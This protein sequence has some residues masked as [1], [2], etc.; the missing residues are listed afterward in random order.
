MTATLRAVAQTQFKS[1]FLTGLSPADRKTVSAAAR[2]SRFPAGSVISSQ[3]TVAD[4]LF[5]LVS[6]R[7]RFFILT[8]EG[9]KIL[10]LWLPVGEVLG[11]AALEPYPANY[12][13]S[14]E[15]VRDSTM[16]VWDRPTIRQLAARFPRLLEN[17]LHSASEYL[18]FY[19]ATHIALTS[20][21]A[22]QRLA[23]LLLNL[24]RGL[25]RVVPN[26]VELDISN[27]ELAQAA[28][29]T[30]FTASRLI[31]HWQKQGVLVKT[32]RKILLCS[33][34]KLHFSLGK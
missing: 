21:T 30:H 15:A 29:V 2:H 4:Q 19:V 12:I 16:L 11:I 25:G 9:Y 6:G 10:L 7:A 5:L 26:G 1:P 20:Q 23:A 17:S 32:R 34:E 33:P 28:N 14:T 24:T 27:E 18:T 31:S 22:E 8:P 13:V 3:G